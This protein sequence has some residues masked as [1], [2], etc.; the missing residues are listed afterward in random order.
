MKAQR[1][2]HDY[3]RDIDNEEKIFAVVRALEIIGEAARH[4]P[5]AWRDKYPRVRWKQVV[6][7]RDKITHEYFAA[8]LEV[9]WKTLHEDLPLLHETATAMLKDLAREEQS[10][11]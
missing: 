1:V 3:V 6:G 2:Y 8:D 9:V 5:K 11:K 7:M 10:S 4:I